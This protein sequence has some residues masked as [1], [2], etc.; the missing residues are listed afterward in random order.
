MS[1][2]N[3]RCYGGLGAVAWGSVE[4]TDAAE[5]PEADAARHGEVQRMEEMKS[6]WK[7]DM[8]VGVL[9]SC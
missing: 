2:S 9:R 6:T 1:I 4:G 3:Y 5:E 8:R 7:A